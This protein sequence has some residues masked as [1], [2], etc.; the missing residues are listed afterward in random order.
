MPFVSA[1]VLYSDAGI[2]SQPTCRVRA[3]LRLQ[4]LLLL[5]LSFYLPAR[6]DVAM[7][8]RVGTFGFSA[9]FDAPL[10]KHTNLRVGYNLYSFTRALNSGDVNYQAS[11]KISALSA[12]ADWHPQGRSMHLSAGLSMT[13]PEARLQATPSGDTYTFNGQTYQAS[14]IGSL[15]GV[16]KSKYPVAP[17]FGV[18]WGNAFGDR[19]RFTLLFELGALYGGGP[20]AKLD[21][22]CNAALATTCDQLIAD[23]NRD[24]GTTHAAPP[25]TP[26]YIRSTYTAVRLIESLC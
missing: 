2:A 3:P 20:K 13:G 14:D 15:N 4:L 21:V 24:R 10:S 17:Y 16:V 26:P 8:Y 1:S 6:A 12:I 7:A 23:I 9:E 11:L 25:P 19:D 22:T 18:G 5:L